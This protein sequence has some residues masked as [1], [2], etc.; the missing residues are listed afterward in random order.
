MK[1]NKLAS[2]SS[3]AFGFLLLHKEAEAQVIYTDVDPDAYVSVL[4]PMEIDLNADGIPEITFNQWSFFT[5]SSF[6][7]GSWGYRIRNIKA[8][9]FESVA[10][11]LIHTSGSEI[12]SGISFTDYFVRSLF[13]GTSF[14]PFGIDTSIGSEDINLESFLGIRFHIGTETHYGWVRL[15]VEKSDPNELPLLRILDYAYNATPDEGILTVQNSAS[16]PH[17]V[18]LSDI[19]NTGTGADL[20]FSFEKAMD[21]SRVSAYHIFFVPGITPLP[22]IAEAESLAPDRYIEVTPS[23]ENITL[24]CTESMSISMEIYLFREQATEQWCFLWQMGCLHP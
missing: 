7:G 22:T 3:A 19:A 24:S 17:Y 8:T 1:R 21:E 11:N 13:Y 4:D 15:S 6:G 14:I 18:V 9:N 10:V 5:F 16:I 2:Y 20:Q 12:N 23:G